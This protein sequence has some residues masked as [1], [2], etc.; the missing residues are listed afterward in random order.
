MA[1]VPA[2]LVLYFRRP[3]P[4]CV[5]RGAH[6]GNGGVLGKNPIL[7]CARTNFLTT[8]HHAL[9]RRGAEGAHMLIS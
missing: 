1:E 4:Q 2:V 6:G 7:I 5:S 8:T 3:V 9:L